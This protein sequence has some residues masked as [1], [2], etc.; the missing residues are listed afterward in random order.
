MTTLDN[1]WALVWAVAVGNV[2]SFAA[3]R[4]YD[5]FTDNVDEPPD[6]EVQARR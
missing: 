3:E 1:W 5:W 6:S 2:I 4:I